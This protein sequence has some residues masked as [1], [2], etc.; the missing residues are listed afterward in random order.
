MPQYYFETTKAE[1]RNHPGRVGFNKRVDQSE[2]RKQSD[3]ANHQIAAMRI[4]DL[5]R[6]L[7]RAVLS[8][9]AS[10]DAILQGAPVQAQSHFAY[11]IAARTLNARRDNIVGTIAV[12]SQQLARVKDPQSAL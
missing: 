7:E 4:E 3:I 12:L 9:D 11:P 6:K 8:L 10:I 1:N 2:T 5:I